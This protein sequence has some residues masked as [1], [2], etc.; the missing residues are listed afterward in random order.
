MLVLAQILSLFSFKS[1]HLQRSKNAGD[2]EFYRA[3]GINDLINLKWVK[4]FLRS[5]FLKAKISE[6][7]FIS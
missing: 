5:K 3:S 1:R 4:N 6:K 7:K 2:A